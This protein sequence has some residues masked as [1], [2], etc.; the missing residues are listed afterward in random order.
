MS[1]YKISY[2]RSVHG[3]EMWRIITAYSKADALRYFNV[4]VRTKEVPA[5]LLGIEE[6]ENG[7][8]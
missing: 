7:K 1:K 2:L 5:W 4:Y 3:L 8:K 6:V